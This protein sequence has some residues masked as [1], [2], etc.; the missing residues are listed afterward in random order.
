LGIWDSLLYI[1]SR[2]GLQNLFQ[3]RLQQGSHAS[4]PL[5]QLLEL[6][7]VDVSPEDSHRQYIGW[8]D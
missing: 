8:F 2:L 4:V 3:D 7:V 1:S 5:K 6:L